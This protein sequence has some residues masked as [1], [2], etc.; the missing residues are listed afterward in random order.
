[1]VIQSKGQSSFTFEYLYIKTRCGKG[2]HFFVLIN[3]SQATLQNTC[4]AMIKVVD[5]PY[6]KDQVGCKYIKE[7]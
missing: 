2:S 5:G 4:V 6:L 1:M 7:Q 3:G